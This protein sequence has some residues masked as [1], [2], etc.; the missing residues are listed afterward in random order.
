MLVVFLLL[1][2]L[3]SGEGEPPSNSDSN[4]TGKN[5]SS[6]ADKVPS[7]R[8]DVWYS[9]WFTWSSTC[10]TKIPPWTSKLLIFLIGLYLSL[11]C[12]CNRPIIKIKIVAFFFFTV[13]TAQ[14]ICIKTLTSLGWMVAISANFIDRSVCYSFKEHWIPKLTSLS[15]KQTSS[16]KWGL[17]S[18]LMI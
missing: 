15:N 4:Q 1:Q 3:F 7:K 11:S 12:K 17:M 14:V 8:P 16:I 13:D 9:S 10:S 2:E 18:F 6:D 5:S